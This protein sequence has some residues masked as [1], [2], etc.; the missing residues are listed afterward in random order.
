MNTQIV[1]NKKTSYLQLVHEEDRSAVLEGVRS[2]LEKRR[3][4]ELTYRIT[5]A[6]NEEKWV[7]E[8]GTGVF[9]W[10]I[11]SP[12]MGGRLLGWSLPAAYAVQG[13]V[14]LAVVI[15]TWWGCRRAPAWELRAALV[16]V[17]TF[18]A[19][20]YAFNYDMTLLSAAVLLVV[21]QT[22]AGG[23]LRF[24]RLA[25]VLAWL[26]PLGVM[27]LNR[28]GLPLGPPVLAL[29]FALVLVRIERARRSAASPPPPAAAP[30]PPSPA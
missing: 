6:A 14:T 15:A 16:G 2:A 20:P 25:L 9:T 18:L 8:K 3:P 7:S 27:P 17:G 30:T 29:A 26:L 23:F 11:A 22:L 4:F 1:K 12:F 24:E 21:G 10:M 19:S 13:V 5:T 28:W